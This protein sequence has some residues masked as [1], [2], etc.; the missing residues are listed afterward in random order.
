MMGNTAF[1][2]VLDDY[3]G[4]CRKRLMLHELRKHCRI[5]RKISVSNNVK[6]L[7]SIHNGTS[8]TRRTNNAVLNGNTILRPSQILMM[9][10][11]VT[12][13]TAAAITAAAINF[14]EGGPNTTSTTPSTTT[15]S[16]I[17]IDP[18]IE[19][20]AEDNKNVIYDSSCLVVETR[21]ENL[22]QTQC[23]TMSMSMSS[24]DDCNPFRLPMKDI[25]EI[26]SDV[27]DEI[28]ND[29]PPSP[30]ATTTSTTTTIKT[31]PTTTFQPL[32]YLPGLVSFGDYG[33]YSK[34]KNDSDNGSSTSSTS[35]TSSSMWS[36]AVAVHML[37]SSTSSSS[38][39]SAPSYL[40]KNNVKKA[41][42]VVDRKNIHYHNPTEFLRYRS[43]R[44]AV[45]HFSQK[46]VCA[47]GR[48]Q[49][50]NNSDSERF[51][52]DLRSIFEDALLDY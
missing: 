4:S 25:R 33:N 51:S 41:M 23:T 52:K 19:I 29:N 47:A 34:V 17:P 30:T 40:V 1:P 50:H 10:R 38:S 3:I 22:E 27:F 15:N 2:E 8:S 21:Q 26:G 43:S 49:S 7:G 20:G 46:Y 45:Y 32:P 44:L 24:D 6:S 28:D 16:E 12:K 9:K 31:S 35:S 18:V 37:S 36:S 13:A 42:V 48:H 14:N 11:E 5:V 39:S